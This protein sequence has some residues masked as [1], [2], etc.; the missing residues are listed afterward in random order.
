MNLTERL[1]VNPMKDVPAKI[2]LEY[3]LNFTKFLIQTFL[4][5]DVETV[6][7]LRLDDKEL[8]FLQEILEDNTIEDVKLSMDT[9]VTLKDGRQVIVEIQI[10]HQE[11]FISRLWA[12][13]FLTASKQFLSLDRRLKVKERYLKIKPIYSLAI[14]KGRYFDDDRPYRTFSLQDTETSED[15]TVLNDKMGVSQDLLRMTIVEVDKYNPKKLTDNERFLYEFYLNKE[16]SSENVPQILLLTDILLGDKGRWKK[17][18]LM[19]WE[20]DDEIREEGRAEGIAEGA[21]NQAL[22]IAR[23]MI[24]D[25]EPNDKIIKYT[26]LPLEKIT[27]LRSK[28][29]PSSV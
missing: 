18:E 22:E 8:P 25:G 1:P 5:L 4:H 24:A 29:T 23:E 20:N 28:L 16:Y 12:Y 10:Q 15:L 11:F 13:T 6:E 9:L 17:E 2:A 26:K 14:V 27:Q 3:D 7:E 19:R 21:E